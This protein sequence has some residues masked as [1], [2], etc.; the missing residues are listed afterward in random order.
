[1]KF[2]L[3]SDNRDTLLGLR[4]S[5]IDGVIVGTR[6]GVL[7]ELK[8]AADDEDVGIVLITEKLTKLCPETIYEMKLVNRRPLVVSI[9][10]RHGSDASEDSIMQYVRDAI[11]VKL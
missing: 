1:M 10:D 5:G 3:I 2:R 9:P 7:R 4:L 8:N 6:E 11:G